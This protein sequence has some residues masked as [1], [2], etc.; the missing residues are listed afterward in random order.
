MKTRLVAPKIFSTGNEERFPKYLTV[1]DKLV[2]SVW[3][4]KTPKGKNL[5]EN[6]PLKDLFPEKNLTNYSARK[7]VSKKAII[8]RCEIKNITGHSSANGL[9]R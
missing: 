2:S 6:S 9:D 4:K 7:T 8:P 1:I 5:K 3:F